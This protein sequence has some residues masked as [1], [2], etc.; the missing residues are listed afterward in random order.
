MSHAVEPM[1][2]GV[3]RD[4]VAHRGPRAFKRA[5]LVSRSALQ[6]G[7]L[8]EPFQVEVRPRRLDRFSE[9]IRRVWRNGWEQE[10]GFTKVQREC[11]REANRLS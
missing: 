2:D 4:G 11:R 1:L 10:A 5:E 6:A 7:F 8:G 3:P 9:F